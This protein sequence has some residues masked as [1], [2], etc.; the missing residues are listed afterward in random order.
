MT[1]KPEILNWNTA[2]ELPNCMLCNGNLHVSAEWLYQCDIL[3]TQE[4]V[5][6]KY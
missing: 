3:S 6:K 1:A 5:M 4:N 2:V